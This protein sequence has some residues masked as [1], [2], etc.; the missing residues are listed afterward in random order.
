MFRLEERPNLSKALD[1]F[2]SKMQHMGISLSKTSK[3]SV[4]QLR[5][6]GRDNTRQGVGRVLSQ[7]LSYCYEEQIHFDHNG[8]ATSGEPY[9][10]PV[11]DDHDGVVLM[12]HQW[13]ALC[14]QKKK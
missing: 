2:K 6:H 14:L 7:F 8:N 13:Q 1:V 12:F 11:L 9:E 4:Y 3:N 5:V 10:R